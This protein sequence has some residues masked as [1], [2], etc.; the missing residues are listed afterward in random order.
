M[1][2][3]SPTPGLILLLLLPGLCLA[4]ARQM[5]ENVTY[6]YAQVL[7]ASPVYETTRSR[8]PEQRCDGPAGGGN[9]CRIVQVDREERHLAGYDVEYQYKGEKYMSRLDSDP[10]NRLRIRISVVP[11]QAPVGYR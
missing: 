1:R 7:R 3:L 5:D 10:G 8:V 6:G 4:E 2:H 9:R 11:E